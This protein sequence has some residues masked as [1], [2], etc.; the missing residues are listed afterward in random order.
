MGMNHKLGWEYVHLH[1]LWTSWYILF[2]RCSW[3][4]I[5]SSFGI[6]PL[7]SPYL[8]KHTKSYLFFLRVFAFLSRFLFY[9]V[10]KKQLEIFSF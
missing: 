6:V 3:V 7:V 8:R 2:Y 1:I 4:F 9:V 10:N 5:F